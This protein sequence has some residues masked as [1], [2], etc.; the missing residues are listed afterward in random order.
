MIPFG[1]YS[2]QINQTQPEPLRAA[3]A[4]RVSLRAS[5]SFQASMTVEA[6]LVLPVFLFFMAEILSVFDMI[7][8]QSRFVQALNETG[9]RM[10]A[11]A[12]YTEYAS[13]N[14]VG[15]TGGAGDEVLQGEGE[16]E[17]GTSMPT[18]YAVSLI[19]TETYVKSHVEDYMG[20]DY[21]NSTCLEGG[22]SSVSYLRSQI[23]NGNDVIDLVADFRVKPVFP[24]FGLRGFP[25][26][27][28]YYGHAWTGYRIGSGEEKEDESG[29]E[30]VFIT[31]NG[32][33]YHRTESCTYL[34]PGTRT[35]AAASLA[36]V[37]STD[38]SIYYPCENCRPAA[39]GNVVITSYGNRYHR[40]SSCSS[41]HRDVTE[42][43][44]SAVK[45]TMRACSKCGGESG[46][47]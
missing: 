36:G 41:I 17:D 6:S 8:L 24:L 38:G 26:Q 22:A 44:L 15:L 40:S 33:V 35:I 23:M 25:L 2:V 12:F 21:L 43:P 32:S 46:R 4:E 19:M 14:A 13:D 10:S 16:D 9:T 28:R 3:H 47:S 34:K 7:R 45:N 30:T 11:Y 5:L 31:T 27:S 18:G 1:I 29:E 39:V 42:V 37:R 20:E